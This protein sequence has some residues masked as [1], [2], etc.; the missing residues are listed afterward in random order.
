MASNRF[1]RF[2]KLDELDPNL[3][4]VIWLPLA[5]VIL[6][7][8]GVIGALTGYV[9][10]PSLVALII[11]I[12][13]ALVLVVYSLG[14]Y[15]Y[16]RGRVM[17]GAWLVLLAAICNLS[18]LGVVYSGMGVIL[19]VI[20]IGISMVVILQGITG[21]GRIWAIVLAVVATYAIFS[22]D[23]VKGLNW[24]WRVAPLSVLTM[25]MVLG[26]LIVL[27][28]VMLA[29][30]FRNLPLSG[31]MITAFLGITLT[32]AILLSVMVY[33]ISR[34]R[35]QSLIGNQ[36][37]YY[38]NSQGVIIGDDLN[39]Q[40]AML[41]SL[42]IDQV[43]IQAAEDANAAYT[44]SQAEIEAGI[45]KLDDEWRASTDIYE[46]L[47]WDRLNRPISLELRGF[48][49]MFPD[50]VEVFLT[51]RNGAIV[52]TTN[53][54]SDYYQADE[55][56]WQ[57]AYK[58][59]AGATYIG[60]PEYDE[61]SQTFAVNM[62]VPVRNDENEV[63]GVLRTTFNVRGILSVINSAKFGKT[64]KFDL[65]LPGESLTVFNQEGE[66][67]AADEV[68]GF[69]QTLETK[70]YIQGEY[71]GKTM[72]LSQAPVRSQDFSADIMNL[73]WKLLT[74]QTTEEAFAPVQD[75]LRLSMIILYLLMGVM[76]LVGYAAA[77]SLIRPVIN[78]S[79]AAEKVSAGDLTARARVTSSDEIGVLAK[80]FNAMTA[81][82][83]D[84]VNSLEQRVAD[85]TRAI[86]ISTEVS[87]RLSTI[88]D[89]QELVT[90]VVKQVQSAFNYYHAHIYLFDEAEENLVMVGGTGEAGQTMLARRHKIP[91]GR[92]LVGRAADTHLPELVP[93][94]RTDPNWLPNPL[95]P[96]T[97]SEVAVPIEI[98]NRVLGVLDVQENEVGGLAQADVDLL[99][100]IASQV[101]I[102]LQNARS[103]S[104]TQQQ[105]E[106]EVLLG[107]ISQ[108]IR[109]TISVDE[110]LQVTVRELG[111]VVG[112]PQ[113]RVR[114]GLAAPEEKK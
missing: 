49:A 80:T 108:K 110:A 14:Y 46:P 73:N 77:Q 98:G 71:E 53:R 56:W 25:Y 37:K 39:K 55:G 12:S 91:R 36:L 43:F 35:L 22:I 84:L 19:S 30:Q 81:Q 20:A 17:T 105:A 64:G 8:L 42:S 60:S 72:L 63:V 87:R 2:F 57:S 89:P 51:D 16:R 47:V 59:G 61:S 4:R 86:E 82:I 34:A 68:T 5:F 54:T 101:A 9:L 69:L 85:R 75:Q 106:R 112:A 10:S 45:L 113:T 95:L 62:A 111:R 15:L 79:R 88:L 78:V 58:A 90:Q 100:S 66:Q 3:R 27:A 33:F 26:G 96:E 104:E 29:I 32:V 23:Q 76:I 18:V 94:T 6:G 11:V 13:N 97:R 44:G 67:V 40:V 114:L 65:V 21:R 74:Q 103:F 109:Q 83:N 92:G 99:Q 28:G 41:K 50:H 93:D 107:T 48:R 38:A 52:A 7:V 31:K 70:D 24:S 1:S 102:A